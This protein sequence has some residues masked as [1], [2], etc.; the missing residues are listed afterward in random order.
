M[1]DV[2]LNICTTQHV[3]VQAPDSRSY[4][5]FMKLCVCCQLK[6]SLSPNKTLQVVCFI[7]FMFAR[8]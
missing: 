6:I 1:F 3:N 2:Q 7:L 4:K 8:I 5:S